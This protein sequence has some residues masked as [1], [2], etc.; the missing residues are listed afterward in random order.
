[1]NKKHII[2]LGTALELLLVLIY[3]TWKYFSGHQEVFS[4][5][6][7]SFALGGCFA[8]GLLLCNVWFIGKIY[9]S[10]G[11]QFREFL[12]AVVL[13]LARE[14][15]TPSAIYISIC[16]GVGEELFFRGF[17]QNELGIIISS[18]AFAFLHFGPAARQFWKIVIVYFMFSL[19]FAGLYVYAQ[20]LL[21]PITA[22]IIYDFLALEYLRGLKAEDS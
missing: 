17:L 3:F 9:R 4:W 12:D 11:G 16:A 10:E 14:L 21:A 19:G 20:N 22:H 7:S 15:D 2:F 8:L 6:F 13:P 5:S 1:M 18:L